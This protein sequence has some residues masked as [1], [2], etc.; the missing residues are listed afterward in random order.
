MK[1]SRRS[2][3]ENQKLHRSGTGLEA[4]ATGQD[5]CGRRS[6]SSEYRTARWG[7]PI[8]TWPRH[9]HT[10]NWFP[11]AASRQL[12]PT[13]RALLAQADRSIVA[14][15]RRQGNLHHH[16]PH[17]AAR[18]SRISTR[19]VAAAGIPGGWSGA[20]ANGNFVVTE[21]EVD[22]APLGKPKEKQRIAIAAGKA[23]FSQDG[24]SARS[25]L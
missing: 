21:I 16:L 7:W 4:R 14:A 24:F 1:P 2:P 19:S 18:H 8:S 13:K 23:D 15:A 22:A 5:C 9:P 20:A 3:P 11:C 12:P 10:T 17:S 6:R 25:H